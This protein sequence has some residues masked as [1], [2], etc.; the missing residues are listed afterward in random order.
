MPRSTTSDPDSS[1]TP[2]MRKFARV[3]M[4]GRS[5]A[6]RLPREF[7]FDTD[8][9]GIRREGCN[10]ILSPLYA[11]WND[12]F[13]NAPRVRDDFVEAMA[14]ARRDLMPL[15]DREPLD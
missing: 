15:E 10:V 14:G 11:D 13:A 12:Y 2:P 4:N 6:V 1:S 5:Q 7:R 3:F 9:V 8:R